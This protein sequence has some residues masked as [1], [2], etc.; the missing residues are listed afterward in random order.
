MLCSFQKEESVLVDELVRLAPDA[1]IVTIDTGVLFPETLATWRAFERALRHRRRDRGRHRRLD[2]AR[3]LLRRGQGR[4]ARAR[5]GRRRRL[6]HRH[7]PRAVADARRRP[8]GR[9]RR[10]ARDLEVQPARRVDR[11]GPL[12]A[13]PRARPAVPPAPRPGL[14]LDRLRPV[15]RPG[16]RPRRPLGRAFQDRVRAAR[17]MDPVAD[18]LR[19][20]RGHPRR[21]HRDGRRQPDDAAADPR[22]RDQAGRRRRLRPGLRRD[23]QDRRRAPALPQGHGADEPRVLARRW[24][25]A[26][27][28]SPA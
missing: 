21:H 3:T 24:A 11:E 27:A 23:H 20:R 16:Q 5:A 13:H 25:P 17:L 9:A 8:A 15:H 12:E 26:R 22:V 4:R 1:R 14:R 2:A 19:L 10:Q 18:R 28:P 6:D 7:P